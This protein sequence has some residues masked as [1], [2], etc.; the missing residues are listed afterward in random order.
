[1]NIYYN[2]LKMHQSAAPGRTEHGHRARQSNAAS[3]RARHQQTTQWYRPFERAVWQLSV[4][5][6][7]ATMNWQCLVDAMEIS[8]QKS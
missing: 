4:W 5:D 1:M 2:E 7:D 6:S 8:F 3:R